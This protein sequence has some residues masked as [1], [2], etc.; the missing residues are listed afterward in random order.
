[1]G[2]DA[3]AD[4]EEQKH[5]RLHGMQKLKG[6]K[7]AAHQLAVFFREQYRRRSSMMAAIKQF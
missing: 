7:A 3:D 4:K 1:M 6:G 5:I 2:K